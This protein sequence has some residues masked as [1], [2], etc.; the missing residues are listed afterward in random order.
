MQVLVPSLLLILPMQN[1]KSNSIKASFTH[2]VLESTV[3]RMGPR[4]KYNTWLQL[5][6]YLFFH[7]TLPL[8]LYYLYITC[9]SVVTYICIGIGTGEGT[10]GPWPPDF[11]TS[12]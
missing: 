12:S 3:L 6:L 8:V 4:F 7:L 1:N 2:D 10:G 11:V 5:V 9:N